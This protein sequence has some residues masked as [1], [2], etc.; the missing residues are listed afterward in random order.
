MNDE[1]KHYVCLKKGTEPAFSGRYLNHKE[2]GTYYCTMCKTAL[3]KSKSKFN[4][5]TGW[6]SFTEAISNN[7]E[8]EI[9]TTHGMIRTEVHCKKCKAHL[10]HVFPDGPPPTGQRYCIN[11]ISLTFIKE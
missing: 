8:T 2:K 10:G 9:D 3:F 4:S 7:I 11:S 1:L 6:P 5:G